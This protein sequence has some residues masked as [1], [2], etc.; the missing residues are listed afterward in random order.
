M[1]IHAIKAIGLA[2]LLSFPSFSDSQS[3]DPLE[4]VLIYG[5][6]H[7][8]VKARLCVHSCGS[9]SACVAG[10]CVGL[11]GATDKWKY[12]TSV[13]ALDSCSDLRPDYCC[14]NVACW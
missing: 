14:E 5:A 7:C 11:D 9:L 6:M 1:G 3:V 8:P 13:C 12:N 4:T 2:A 10:F